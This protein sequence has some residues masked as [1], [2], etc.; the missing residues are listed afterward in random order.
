MSNNLAKWKIKWQKNDVEQACRVDTSYP[1]VIQWEI[2]QMMLNNL[3]KWR[4][5]GQKNDVEQ[6]CRVDTSHPSVI[7]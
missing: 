5:K 7:Q 3:A 2:K 4:I 6:A 1:I